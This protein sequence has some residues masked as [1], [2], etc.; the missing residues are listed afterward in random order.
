MNKFHS[1]IKEKAKNRILYTVHAVKQMN[2]EARL[3][4]TKEVEFKVFEGE[5]IEDYPEDKR[6]HSCLIN[7]RIKQ[8]PI[9]VVCAPKDDY[10]A[11][12][13]AYLPNKEK[14]EIN[15]KKRKKL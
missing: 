5:I 3:I 2:S 9:H 11:V 8:R 6:G 12:I 4:S 1:T 13:T 10:L 15:F 7:G 14:W